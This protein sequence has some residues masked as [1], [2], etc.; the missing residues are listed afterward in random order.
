MQYE[1][2]APPVDEKVLQ[3]FPFPHGGVPRV[4]SALSNREPWTGTLF[5]EGHWQLDEK[6]EVGE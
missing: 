1:P 4:R 6:L 5:K 3:A 2:T